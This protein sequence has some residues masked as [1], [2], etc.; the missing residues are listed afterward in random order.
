MGQQRKIGPY[1]DPTE[2]VLLFIQC[3]PDASTNSLLPTKKLEMQI[4]EQIA[5]DLSRKHVP[6]YVF[7]VAKIPYNANGKKMEIQVKKIV[8]G[9]GG[10]TRDVVSKEESE[11]V[12]QFEQFFHLENLMKSLRSPTA[13][14]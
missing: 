11:V 14:L 6:A 3:H 9:E 2:R 4:K 7:E 1:S 5:T 13:N 12:G 10:Q 8:N